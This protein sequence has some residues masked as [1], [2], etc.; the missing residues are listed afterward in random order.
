MF[1]SLRYYDYKPQKA[2]IFN[3]SFI[4]VQTED[5]SLPVC[6]GVFV[7]SVR[8]FT[9]SRRFIWFIIF[10][11]H[12]LYRNII[13]FLSYTPALKHL[14]FRFIG[15][16]LMASLLVRQTR[17]TSV[18]NAIWFEQYTETPWFIWYVL[19]TILLCVYKPKELIDV[20][21]SFVNER[22]R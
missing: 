13:F 5:W 1:I 7:S 18:T 10:R 20:S 16:L 4:I 2:W 21:V 19:L 6:S 14:P 9:L 8:N 22:R 12:P 3:N 11:H 15:G 17:I